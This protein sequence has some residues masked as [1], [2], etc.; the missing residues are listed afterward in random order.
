MW[1]Y[2]CVSLIACRKPLVDASSI[3]GCYSEA[4]D[5]T[6]LMVP[7]KRTEHVDVTAKSLLSGS[8]RRYSDASGLRTVR[9][10]CDDH[11]ATDSSG[12]EADRRCVRRYVQ[13][14]R[15]ESRPECA[16]RSKTA[17]KRKAS[18]DPSPTNVGGEGAAPRFRGVRRRPWGKYAAEIR[19]PWRRVRVWLGTFDTAEE[20]A[21][22]YDSAAI[23]LRGPDA[24]TNFSKPAPPATATVQPPP[25]PLPTTKCLSTSNQT[26]VSG[27]YDSGD[28]SRNL[29]SPTSVLRGFS[30]FT[31]STTTSSET[32]ER[33]STDSDDSSGMLTAGISLPW[34]LSGFLPM[35]EEAMLSDDFL[36][37]GATEPSLL[38]DCGQIGFLS[39]D[40]NQ[41]FVGS[42]LE[43]GSSTCQGGEDF[44]QEIVDLFPIE[45]LAAM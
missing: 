45:P 11:D 17:K 44:F 29:S 37:F 5:P 27:G 7:V 41:S 33:P 4:M 9:I 39:G 24:T 14:I 13:E 35:E 18:A 6:L 25:P 36:G 30:S 34:Q 8:K 22:V 26:S 31:A 20:A 28:E 42:E 38:D 1:L 23:Q 2:S 32:A 21:K 12:D 16:G 3:E 43:F 10:F 40:F 19:D 15:F